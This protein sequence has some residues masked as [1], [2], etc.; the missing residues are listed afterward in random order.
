[1]IVQAKWLTLAVCF[2]LS[3]PVL[4]HDYW[5]KTQGDDYRLYRGHLFSLH[6]GKKEVPFDPSII[7]EARCL[8]KGSNASQSAEYSDQYPPLIKGPCLALLVK[9]DSGY[10]SQTMTGTKNKP[11][12]QLFGVLRSWH[13]LEVMKLVREWDERLL[14][15]LSDQLELVFTSNPFTLSVGDKLR[16]VVMLDGKPAAGVS[17]AYDGKPRGVTGEDGRVTLRI[18]HE[19]TQVISASIEQ[20]INSSSADKRVRSTMLTFNIN[21]K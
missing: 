6:E 11:K 16:L 20:T 18:R 21:N 12:D 4:A 14:S 9:A 1:M 2:F 7:T 13:S 10:W 3:R 17:F 15:S 5:F 19:G 8:Q